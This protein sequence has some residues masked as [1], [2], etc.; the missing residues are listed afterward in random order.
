MDQ[1]A[2]PGDAARAELERHDIG[3]GG[4]CKA[5]ECRQIHPCAVRRTLLWALWRA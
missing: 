1:S 3:R 4:L 5:P 2:A